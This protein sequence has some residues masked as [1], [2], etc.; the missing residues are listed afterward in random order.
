MSASMVDSPV[1]T[2]DPR[3]RA[4]RTLVERGMADQGAVDMFATLLEETTQTYGESSI[5]S[6][7]AYYEYGNALLRAAAIA[8]QQEDEQQQ[9]QQQPEDGEKKPSVSKE[10]DDQ[11]GNDNE[12]SNDNSTND[13]DPNEEEEEEEEE[14]ESDVPLALTMMENAYSILDDYCESSS[15]NSSCDYSKWVKEQ[16]PRVLLGIG[17]TLSTLGR[18]ADAADA[19]SRS[20]EIRQ[21]ELQEFSNNNNN[22]TA[23]ATIP[24]LVAHRKVVEAT[25]LVAEELLACPPDQDVVTTETSSLIVKKEERIAYAK[26][27]YDKARDALQEAVFLM[28]KLAAANVD[29]G[30]EKEDVCFLATLVMGVGESLAAIDEAHDTQPSEPVQ[31]KAKR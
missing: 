31:K 29:L 22:D 24:Q 2:S 20:L 6:A 26:G 16:F 7:P 17:D 30:R 23:V 19:Y 25:I 1:V 12:E 9:Q 3:F 5:E 10:K 15:N 8:Q 27:Y 4:G 28:G 14:E 11:S 21:N 18:H 13:E